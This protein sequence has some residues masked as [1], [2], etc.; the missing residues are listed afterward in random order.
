MSIF[1]SVYSDLATWYFH[2]TY[3]QDLIHIYVI[4][5]C[6]PV[7]YHL[8]PGFNDWVGLDYSIV[9]GFKTTYSVGGNTI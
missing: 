1:D 5:S 8:H 2:G 7:Q 3:P 4:R 6:L 9:N